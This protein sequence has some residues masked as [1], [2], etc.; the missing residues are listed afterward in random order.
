[1]KKKTKSISML[2]LVYSSVCVCVCVCVY[3]CRREGVRVRERERERFW[4]NMQNCKEI[5]L[6][7]VKHSLWSADIMSYTLLTGSVKVS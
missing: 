7:F 2:F 1:M 3:V 6:F 4:T 5:S